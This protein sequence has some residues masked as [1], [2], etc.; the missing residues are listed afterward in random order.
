VL[1][2]QWQLDLKSVAMIQSFHKWLDHV[3]HPSLIR[4]CA[5]LLGFQHPF[6]F[7]HHHDELYKRWAEELSQSKVTLVIVDDANP[8]AQYES[9]GKLLGVPSGVIRASSLRNT[10]M[11]QLQA[12][13]L[14][15]VHKILRAEGWST[16]RF[17]REEFMKYLEQAGYIPDQDVP[18]L[19]PEWAKFEVGEISESVAAVLQQPG[20]RLMGDVSLLESNRIRTANPSNEIE[21]SASMLAMQVVEKIKSNR[22]LRRLDYFELA[23]KMYR[24]MTTLRRK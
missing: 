19:L 10:S 5:S 22:T 18:V 6:W 3:L 13:T 24:R 21:D 11:K 4:R 23:S 12:D 7:R 9:F 20:V 1:P 2:S 15:Q 8:N 17:K 16:P 14:L